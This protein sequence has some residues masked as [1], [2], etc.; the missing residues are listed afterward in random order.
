MNEQIVNDF[1]MYPLAMW[2]LSVVPLAFSA[3][4]LLVLVLAVIPERTSSKHHR[5]VAQS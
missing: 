2:T 5:K 3:L 1:D 4:T